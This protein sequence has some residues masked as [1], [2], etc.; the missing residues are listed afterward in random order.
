MVDG[1]VAAAT[2]E[3]VLAVVFHAGIGQDIVGPEHHPC[4]GVV[5]HRHVV[6]PPA[7]SDGIVDD[8][9]AIIFSE[10]PEV[11][12]SQ[13]TDPYISRLLGECV[14]IRS[15]AIE[16]GTRCPDERVTVCGNDLVELASTEGMRAWCEPVRRIGPDGPVVRENGVTVIACGITTAP[17]GGDEGPPPR[18]PS[19]PHT[20]TGGDVGPLAE[21]AGSTADDVGPTGD[22]CSRVNV[23]Q[24]SPARA[25]TP[26]VM[27]ATSAQPAGH[28]RA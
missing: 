22:D 25:I 27:Q 16:N 6:D 2:L 15:L 8:S 18:I 14:E 5:L 1:H 19:L 17:L 13:V 11:L 4:A 24:V 12:D 26:A 28:R 10:C 23:S 9:L 3:P 7:G 20:R 21:D